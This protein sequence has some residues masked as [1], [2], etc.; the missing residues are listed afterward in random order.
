LFG[1]DDAH[2][3]Q[4]IHIQSVLFACL[5]K[6]AAFVLMER[7]HE[8]SSSQISASRCRGGHPPRLVTNG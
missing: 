2:G 5:R 8:T 7:D 6:A 1:S 4:A 3:G